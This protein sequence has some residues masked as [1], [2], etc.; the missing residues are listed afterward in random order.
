MHTGFWWG[1]EGKSALGRLRSRWDD[2]INMDLQEVEWGQVAGSCECG[3]ESSGSIKCGKFY[4]Y[5]RNRQLL[6]K[7]SAAWSE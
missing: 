1:N 2:N 4:D 3:N 6:K 5:L 7:D